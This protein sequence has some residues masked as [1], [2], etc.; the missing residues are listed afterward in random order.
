MRNFEG[1]VS[2]LQLVV[3]GEGSSAVQ[4]GV[5]RDLQSVYTGI[6]LPPVLTVSLSLAFKL[7]AAA[8]TFRQRS[9]CVYHR[10]RIS[11]SAGHQLRQVQ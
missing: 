5:L 9:S 10:T 7:I 1:K 3:S 11:I 8:Y 2:H 4:F 6:P